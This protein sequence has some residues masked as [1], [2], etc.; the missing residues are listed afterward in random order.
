[1]SHEA[2]H[3]VLDRRDHDIGDGILDSIL[4]GAAEERLLEL[5]AETGLPP[6]SLG[7]GDGLDRSLL[8]LSCLMAI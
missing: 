7:R 5:P 4:T 6:N 2:V 8:R 3:Q 1:M